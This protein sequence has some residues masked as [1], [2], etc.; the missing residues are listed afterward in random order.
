MKTAI[1]FTMTGA[2]IIGAFSYAV[3][4]IADMP[5]V[6]VSYETNQ[7]VEVV[8][9]SDSNYTCENLPKRFNHIWVK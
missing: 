5:D 6:Y 4:T 9:Y 3:A 8:N 1:Y 2:A 7:C